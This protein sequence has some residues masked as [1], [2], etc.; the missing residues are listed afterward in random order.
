MYNTNL[1]Y[2]LLCQKRYALL[3][4]I[5]CEDLDDLLAIEPNK[6]TAKQKKA[7]SYLQRFEKSVNQ[8]KRN[9]KML[10]KLSELYKHRRVTKFWS[11]FP[12]LL[13]IKIFF[14]ENKNGDVYVYSRCNIYGR[15]N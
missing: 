7:I 8:G 3:D 5:V 12:I 11:P 4:A 9:I 13:N 10:H 14:E 15:R 6:R 1:Y 2:K